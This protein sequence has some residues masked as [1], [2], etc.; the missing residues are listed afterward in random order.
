MTPGVHRLA[1][2]QGWSGK[3]H[4]LPTEAEW[5]YACRAGTNTRYFCGDDPEGLVAFGNIADGTA[6]AKYPV[7]LTS[8]VARETV[9]STRSA[10]RA[11]SANAWGGDMHGRCRVVF[12]RLRSRLL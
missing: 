3:V 8:A 7:F 4:R 5:E 6:K 9:T 2:L 1:E 10:G 11:A 12:R